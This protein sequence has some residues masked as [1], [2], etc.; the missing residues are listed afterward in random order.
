MNRHVRTRHPSVYKSEIER[1]KDSDQ[2][3][4]TNEINTTYNIKTEDMKINDKELD[5]AYGKIS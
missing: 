5:D 4:I 3:D 1:K 2:I